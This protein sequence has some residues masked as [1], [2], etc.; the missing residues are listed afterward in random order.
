MVYKASSRT[1]SIATVKSCLKRTK[2]SNKKFSI[3]RLSRTRDVTVLVV[4]VA[5]V[6]GHFCNIC[7]WQVE[8]GD[9]CL[10]LL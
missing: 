9:Q 10:Q 4:F 7:L 2:T 5:D 6:V 8:A 3:I 1:D